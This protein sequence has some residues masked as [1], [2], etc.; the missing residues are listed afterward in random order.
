[1]ARLE[2][3]NN[4]NEERIAKLET[5][6]TTKNDQLMAWLDKRLSPVIF[7]EKK[8][9]LKLSKWAVIVYFCAKILVIFGSNFDPFPPAVTAS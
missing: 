8:L 2:L 9:S 1:M 5:E 3:K 6:L 7:L 4:A